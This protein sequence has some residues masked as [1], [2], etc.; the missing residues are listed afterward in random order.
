MIIY[1][2]K[3]K[4]DGKM[5]IGQTTKTL[6]RR[7]Y[8]H[9]RAESDCRYLKHAIQLHGKESFEVSIIARCSSIEEMNHRETYYIKLFKAIAPNGYNLTTGGDNK[10]VSGETKLKQSESMKKAW[11]EKRDNWPSRNGQTN[12]EASKLKVA[13]SLRGIK[14]TE[15]RNK[16]QSE[17]RKQRCKDGDIVV[18]NKGTIGVMVS[19]NKG[20]KG[21]CKPNSGSFAEDK[22]APNKGRKRVIVDGKI[23]YIKVEATNDL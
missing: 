22:D 20:T 11:Q 6:E 14:H 7:W 23:K 9:C 2:I 18:W 10:K 4:I 16:K 12:S 8:A 17:T 3:N 13:D 19:W 15:D 1:K 5:Y 21:I